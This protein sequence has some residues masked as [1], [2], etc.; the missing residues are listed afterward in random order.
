MIGWGPELAEADPISATAPPN[1]DKRPAGMFACK[2][3]D[4]GS[5]GE[6]RLLD[7]DTV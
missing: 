4:R 7:S 5:P 6:N 1:L 2:R 3:Y